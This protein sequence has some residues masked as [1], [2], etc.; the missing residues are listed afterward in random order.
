MHPRDEHFPLDIDEF[1]RSPSGEGNRVPTISTGER[2]EAGRGLRGRDLQGN[3]AT[4]MKPPKK[5]YRR[6]A[7]GGTSFLI[8]N[9]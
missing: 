5:L 8:A 1:A 9:P 6:R 3:H 4:F 2:G 7:S